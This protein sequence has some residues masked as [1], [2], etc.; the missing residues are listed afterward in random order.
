MKPMTEAEKAERR[1]KMAE[2][3]AVRE[4]ARAERDALEKQVMT[5]V[6]EVVRDALKDKE[7]TTA[8]RLFAVAVLDRICYYS[9]VPSDT[10]HLLQTADAAK[11]DAEIRERLEPIEKK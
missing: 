2:R 10:R 8:Q 3:K 11:M 4:A 6:L 9:F 1:A 5:L 7:A